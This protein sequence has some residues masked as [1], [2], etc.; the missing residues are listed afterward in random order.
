VALEGDVKSGI[1]RLGSKGATREE[2]GKLS[3]RAIYLKPQ[4]I[5]SSKERISAHAWIRDS[6]KQG[7]KVVGKGYL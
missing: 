7:R 6:A 2:L 5:R 3:V 4:K 1:E